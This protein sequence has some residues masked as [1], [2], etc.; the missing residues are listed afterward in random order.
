LYSAVASKLKKLRSVVKKTSDWQ[1]HN[2]EIKN[3]K[4]KICLTDLNV[5]TKKN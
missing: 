1:Y 3:Y 2:L 5:L 4:S